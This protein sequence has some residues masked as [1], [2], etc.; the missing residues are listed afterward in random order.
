M[1]NDLQNLRRSSVVSLFGPGAVVDFRADNA[2]VSGMA[3]GLEE[4]DSSFPPAG[5][6]NKQTVR[7]TRLQKKLGVQ[8]FRLPPVIEERRSD[9]DPDLRRL[10]AVRFPDWLQCPE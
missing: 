5:L 1:A 9:E 6:A 2:P 7:E 3:A 4:W 10:V 8:G